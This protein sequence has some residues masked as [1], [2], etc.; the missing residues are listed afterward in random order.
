MKKTIIGISLLLSGLF[1]GQA[2][3]QNSVAVGTTCKQ[4]T[5]Q[6]R[7]ADCQKPA[8]ECAVNNN[9]PCPFDGLNLTAD[10]QAKLKE[11]A[12]CNAKQAKKE[13]KDKARQER[14]EAAQNSRREYLAKVKNILTPEQY[15]QF[16][17]NSY[18]APARHDGRPF[19]RKGKA[20]KAGMKTKKIDGQRVMQQR[21]NV[22]QMQQK[23]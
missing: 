23:Q 19:D 8:G 3:A 12:P 20:H 2:A 22:Q 16:L 9:R 15:V 6:C 14:R 17:E 5:E 10:Q 7:Q 11:I 1:A 4:K 18:L 13:A 21:G